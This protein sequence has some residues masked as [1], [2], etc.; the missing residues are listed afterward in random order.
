MDSSFYT[1]NT[2]GGFPTGEVL[3]VEGT[4]FDFRQGRAFGEFINSDYPQIKL[5]GGYDHNFALNGRGQRK[6]AEVTDPGSGRVM[7][8]WTD[9]AA[10]QLFTSN[11]KAQRTGKGGAAYAQHQGFCLETQVFPDA[12]A[13]PW[14]VSSYY[15]AGQEYKTRTVYKFGLI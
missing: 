5:F 3:S 6:I 12:P 2:P 14:L 11:G 4:P 7:E 10:V 13:M 8:T 15:K 9:Q 1:P